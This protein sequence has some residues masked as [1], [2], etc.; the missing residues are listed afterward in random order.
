[1]PIKIT[2]VSRTSGTFYN[3][4]LTLN[5]KI[6]GRY[7]LKQVFIPNTAF[8]IN[9][10]NN[11]IYF[12]EASSVITA[13]I[14][15]GFYTSTT[16]PTAVATAMN[17]ATTNI[18]TYTATINTYTGVMTINGSGAFR[19][20]FGTRTNSAAEVLGFDRENSSSIGTFSSGLYGVNLNTLTSYNIRIV[21]SVGTIYNS[22]FTNDGYRYAFIVPITTNSM[23][24]QMYESGNF[25]QYIDIP[26]PRDTFTISVVDDQLNLVQLQNNWSF[27]LDNS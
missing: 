25:R 10:T 13:T 20:M 2:S 19:M 11:C 12:S 4:T 26:T 8:N 16:L 5:K 27:V 21:D 7:F 14:T 3:Y 6:V 15:P 23:E 1:M 22:T 17:A 9:A 24:V 18:T